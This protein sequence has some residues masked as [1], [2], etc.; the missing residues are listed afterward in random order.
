MSPEFYIVLFIK[1]SD[2][3][4]ITASFCILGN[5]GVE[6]A[7]E[8]VQKLPGKLVVKQI[9]NLLPHIARLSSLVT[10]RG[11]KHKPAVFVSVLR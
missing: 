9:G 3:C 1:R 6:K 2:V 11:L 4:I 7:T 8:I 5:R 10:H